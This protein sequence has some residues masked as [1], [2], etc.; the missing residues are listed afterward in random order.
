MRRGRR[1]GRRHRG[2]DWTA[3]RKPGERSGQGPEDRRA[4][5]RERGDCSG[6][7]W[8]RDPQLQAA[9]V[10]AQKRVVAALQHY[11]DARR[12]LR[13]QVPC[14]P[15]PDAAYRATASAL[16]EASTQC[17]R[18]S[19][20]RSAGGAARPPRAFGRR[21]A[22]R[23][24]ERAVAARLREES[25]MPTGPTRRMLSIGSARSSARAGGSWARSGRAGARPRSACGRSW[26]PPGRR[27]AAA[28]TP[29]RRPRR[30]RRR[31]RSCCGAGWRSRAAA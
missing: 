20:P 19:S 3:T 27:P 28:S 17:W 8:A 23:E 12:A 11:G 9:K 15:T 6:G 2:R 13:E 10:G 7:H 18:R 16:A 21:R 22:Q 14:D 24:R 4:R 31:R 29:P 25:S 26:P 5:S 1:G 30:L